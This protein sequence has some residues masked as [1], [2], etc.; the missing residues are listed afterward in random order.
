MPDVREFQPV[1]ESAER[2]AAAG[3]FA[4]A[5]ALLREAA[6]LQESSLGPQHP[7]LASTYNNLAVACEMADKPADAEQFYRR[8]YAIAAS[9]LGPE[10]ALVITSRDN[11]REFCKARGLSFEAPET[12]AIPSA[13]LPSDA[14]PIAALPGTAAPVVSGPPPPDLTT[15]HTEAAAPPAESGPAPARVARPTAPARPSA[16]AP[17]AAGVGAA[18]PTAPPAGVNS[19]RRFVAALL[20]IAVLAA[21][22]VARQWLAPSRE[23]DAS[24]PAAVRDGAQATAPAAPSPAPSADGASAD[25]SA[26]PQGGATPAAAPATPPPT[27]APA[28]VATAPQPTAPAPAPVSAAAEPPVPTPTRTVRASG[29]PV[30]AAAS[31][32][33]V[34]AAAS[35]GAASAADLRVVTATVCHTLTTAAGAWRCESAGAD[36]APGRFSYLTRIASPRPVRVR[37]RWYQGDRLRQDVGLAVGASP[38]EGYRTFSRQTVSAGE[39]RVDL[40]AENGAVLESTRFVVR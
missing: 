38:R 6:E 28:T 31:G 32:A 16:P 37:H 33:P 20:I 15:L 18:A 10:H 40:V 5:E 9:A 3:D 8:A 21:I 27:S 35:S 30:G 39:W 26:A 22:A 25:A 12:G 36:S 17:R 2:A 7:D 1:V 11:L 19:T 24:A 29:A 23:P 14:V 4:G 13:S 34:G